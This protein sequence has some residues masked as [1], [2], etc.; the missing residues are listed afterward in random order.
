MS[1]KT[2]TLQFVDANDDT[3]IEVRSDL[4]IDVISDTLGA[5]I[6]YKLE[7][8]NSLV[9]K[10]VKES[11]ANI[12]SVSPN[13]IKVD[14]SSAQT[15]YIN[16]DR[17]ANIDTDPNDSTQSKVQYDNGGASPVFLTLNTDQKT[18][19]KRIEE[20][21]GNTPHEFDDMNITND[22]I[23]IKSGEGDVSGS[24][25]DGD[26]IYVFGTE[27]TKDTIFTVDSVSHSGNTTVTV[28]ESIPS[29]GGETGYIVKRA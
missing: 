16:A 5:D 11:P 21:D 18:V 9:R 27:S 28:K 13:L 10:T 15:M 26:L 7:S 24:Y 17:I 1:Q 19:R 20:K 8:T 29:D 25:S 6:S 12:Q 23:E 4:M 2:E 3:T 14:H 22:D